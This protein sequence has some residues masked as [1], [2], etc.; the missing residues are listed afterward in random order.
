[1]DMDMD[2]EFLEGIDEHFQRLMKLHGNEKGNG[3]PMDRSKEDRLVAEIIEHLHSLSKA[4][5]EEVLTFMRSL[6]KQ[7]VG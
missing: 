4:Q 2:N 6:R 1:M 3:H 5:K 7:K